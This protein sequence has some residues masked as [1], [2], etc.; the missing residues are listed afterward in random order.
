MSDTLHIRKSSLRVNG[1]VVELEYDE[2]GDIFEIIFE[3]GRATSAVELTDSIILRFDRARRKP[4]S[5]S[6]LSFSTLTSPASL[7]PRSFRL[8]GLAHLPR[9]LR[10]EVTKMI[11]APPV[12]RFLQVASYYPPRPKRAKPIPITFVQ[13][14]AL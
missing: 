10:E 1:S 14:T 6:L 2:D 12:N 13:N 7:G 4:L 11:T 9:E 8:T 3:R 5:L